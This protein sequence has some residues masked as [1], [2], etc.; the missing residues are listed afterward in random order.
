MATNSNFRKR[1]SDFVNWGT[2]WGLIFAVIALNFYI[3]YR[4]D[5]QDKEVI[6][7]QYEAKVSEADSLRAVKSQLER[8]LLEIKSGQ[9]RIKSQELSGRNQIDSE[10]ILVSKAGN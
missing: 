1:A 7:S 5:K 3:D 9:N 8:Q 10:A 2:I 4:Q 6:R